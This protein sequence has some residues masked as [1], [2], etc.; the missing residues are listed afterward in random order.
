[1]TEDKSNE[2]KNSEKKLFNL[3]NREKADWEKKIN[4]A[5]GTCGTLTKVTIFVSLESQKERRKNGELK[6]DLKI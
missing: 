2:L 5:S 6:K 4:K 1:M 3:N